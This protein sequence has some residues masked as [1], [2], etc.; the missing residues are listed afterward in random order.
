MVFYYNI[1]HEDK[2][3]YTG[4]NY[5]LYELAESVV[6]PIINKKL[7]LYNRYYILETK[8]N[9]DFV[10]PPSVKYK[11]IDDLLVNVSSKYLSRKLDK[12]QTLLTVEHL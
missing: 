10:E 4:S 2:V 5:S 6:N 9:A 1:F 7:K 8:Q 12:Q 11:F 3:I